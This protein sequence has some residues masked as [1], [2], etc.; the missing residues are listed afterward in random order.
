ME[1]CLAKVQWKLKRS[2]DFFLIRKMTKSSED[3]L[4]EKALLN[5]ES[6]SKGLE[7]S[8]KEQ[9]VCYN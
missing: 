4:T 8:E 6:M 9:I 1:F 7:T 5:V 3:T 2:V